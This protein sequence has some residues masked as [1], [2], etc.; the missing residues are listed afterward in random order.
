MPMSTLHDREGVERPWRPMSRAEIEALVR[1][2]STAFEV[3]G[4]RER[5][6]RLT[7]ER[8]DDPAELRLDFPPHV[9]SPKKYLFPNWERL[10]RFRTAGGV[11]LEPDTAAVPR[12]IFGMHPCDLHAVRILDHC[13]YEGEADSA[14]R[15]KRQATVLVGTD[16]TPDA[17]CFCSSLGTDRVEGGFDLFLHRLG[18]GYLVQ[19]GSDRGEALLRRHAPAAADRPG[20]PPIPL[21]AKECTSRLRFRSESLSPLLEDAYD[22]P[23]WK[24]VGERCLGCGACTLLCPTC[25]CFN[26]RDRLD[27]DLA[28]GERVRTWDS[29]QFDRFTRISEGAD[30]RADQGDRQRHRFF[31]KYRYLWEKHRRT[32]CV[33]C[34][35]CSRECLSSIEPVAV[36]NELFEERS[37]PPPAPDLLPGAEYRPQPAQILS[38]EDLTPTEKLF[39]LRL[40]TPP[41]F[42]PGAFLAVSVFGLG[43]APFSIASPPNAGAEIELVIRAA[44][45]LTRALHRLEAGESVG[46][47][48]PFGAGFPLESFTGRDVLLVAGGLGMITLRSLLLSILARRSDFGRVHLL[49]G[50][51]DVPHFLFRNDLLEWHRSGIIDC[52]FAVEAPRNEWGLPGA[53][54]THLFRE[55]DVVASRTTAAVSGPPQMYRF[56][57]PLLLRLGFDE[58]HLFLNLE[59]RMKCGLGKCGKCRINDI[60]VCECGPIFPYH[61]VRHLREAIER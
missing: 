35:R 14:Y 31:R 23:V 19:V 38:V 53:E 13:L 12:V 2:L 45:P 61:R 57:N 6:G 47:R 36:L 20:D 25:Y 39:R 27:L 5:R 22:H 18:G 9:H 55:L 33:G 51:R 30:G 34:G 46:V 41:V 28:G 10:F 24:S 29:C 48:G 54:V 7:L 1:S 40:P 32:A 50:A 11:L 4:V 44:G 37:T 56:V 16:C 59:R 17:H 15:A 26:V 42:T 8:I 21:Q 52:R 43:E 49:Y 60:C 3:I 58:D